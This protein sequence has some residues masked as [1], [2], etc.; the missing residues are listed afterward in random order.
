VLNL[1]ETLSNAKDYA[2]QRDYYYRIIISSIGALTFID[3]IRSQLPE[4]NILQ[5]IPGFYLILLFGSLILLLISSDFLVC[6]PAAAD[7]RKDLGIKM[8]TKLNFVLAVR[9]SFGYILGTLI[10]VLNTIVPLSLDSFNY[11]SEN[12]LENVWSLDEVILIEIVLLIILLSLSQSPVTIS[13]SL[14]NEK[15]MNRLPA[16]W[17][18]VILFSVI[19]AGVVTP[20]VDGYTQFG[21]ASSAVSLYLLIINIIKKRVIIKFLGL[22]SL[23]S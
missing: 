6:A 20:T 3:I 16:I 17:R 5:L 4:V 10:I 19:F 12:S 14:G 11:Y 8:I 2:V 23:T 15:S 13:S 21:F 1:D 9:I 18:A 22:T 7:R